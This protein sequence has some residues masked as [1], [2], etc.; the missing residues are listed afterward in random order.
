MHRYVV[1]D[2]LAMLV[3]NQESAWP[4][5]QLLA[6]RSDPARGVSLN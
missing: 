5:L 1:L 6:S 4:K 3:E 2:A